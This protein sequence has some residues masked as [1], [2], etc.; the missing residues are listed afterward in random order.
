MI[1]GPA[2]WGDGAIRDVPPFMPR[3]VPDGSQRLLP[4]VPPKP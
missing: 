1:V 3:R 4:L 2:R